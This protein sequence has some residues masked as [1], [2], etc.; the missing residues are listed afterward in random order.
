[1]L[2]VAR[3]KAQVWT[4]DL[5]LK[6]VWIWGEAGVGKSRWAADQSPMTTTLKKTHDHWWDGY[7]LALTSGVIVENYPPA[8]DG[9]RLAAEVKH[10]GDRAP[11]QAGVKGSTI[12]VDPGKFTLIVT[13][14]Y[15]IEQCFSRPQDRAAM[16]ERFW[17]I[18][19]TG[20]NRE[21]LL[22]WRLD[23]SILRT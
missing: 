9:D 18:A 11:F 12:L 6:N 19:M 10:W 8:P 21:A 23:R 5:H 4:G 16:R 3:A 20:E 7:S 13:S 2:E 22:Q 14:N 1:M 17:E 15:S